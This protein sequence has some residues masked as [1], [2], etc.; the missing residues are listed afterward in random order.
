MW[1][2]LL[3]DF[4]IVRIF[5][6]N[7]LCVTRRFHVDR[8]KITMV[9]VNGSHKQ[10]G[11]CLSVSQNLTFWYHPDL[12]MEC[13]WIAHPLYSVCFFNGSVAFVHRW[14]WLHHWSWLCSDS[15]LTWFLLCSFRRHFRTLCRTE[16]ANDQQTHKMIPF[17]TIWTRSGKTKTIY[18]WVSKHIANTNEN[19]YACEA[20]HY[21]DINDDSHAC[22][23][24][25]DALTIVQVHW[26]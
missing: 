25:H 5:C 2:T 1:T 14:L 22:V 6:Q 24:P 8:V 11:Y 15:F 12:T 20:L 16:V 19:M 7:V 26:T 18:E 21:T 23:A 4:S 10:R 3:N 17:V 13:K 9:F